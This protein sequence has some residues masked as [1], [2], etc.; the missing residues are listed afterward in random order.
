MLKHGQR[1]GKEFATR[2][3]GQKDRLC[4]PAYSPVSV[5]VAVRVGVMELRER[6]DI[7]CELNIFGGVGGGGGWVEVIKK[8]RRMRGFFAYTIHQGI[9]ALT[10]ASAD[11]HHR[12]TSPSRHVN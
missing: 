3:I 10:A 5:E 9:F 8:T 7:S 6:R 4:R 1:A 2:W 12:V 11:E